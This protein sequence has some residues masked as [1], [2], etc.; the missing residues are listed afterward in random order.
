M[1]TLPQ[2]PAYSANEVRPGDE[3]K[4]TVINLMDGPS[5]LPGADHIREG[6]VIRPMLEAVSE[7]TGTRKI[8][9]SISE[10]YLLRRGGTE[11]R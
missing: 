5:T 7:L 8:A 9:K 1:A 4:E 11:L 3:P 2:I 10:H 6:I